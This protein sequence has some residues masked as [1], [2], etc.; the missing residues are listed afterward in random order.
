MFRH[1]S[2]VGFRIYAVACARAWTKPSAFICS[3]FDFLDGACSRPLMLFS[4]AW[5]SSIKS[6]DQPGYF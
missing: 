2:E 4:L 6:G 3:G 1:A 5:S